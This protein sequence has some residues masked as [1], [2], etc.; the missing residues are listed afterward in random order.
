MDTLKS[1]TGIALTS[2]ALALLSSVLLSNSLEVTLTSLVNASNE[3]TVA[4]KV[5]ETSLPESMLAISHTPF[6]T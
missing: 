2:G 1:A 6:P 3:L 4:Y 5:K